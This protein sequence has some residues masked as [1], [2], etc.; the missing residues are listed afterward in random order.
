MS[1]LCVI[2]KI[3]Q[4]Y[5]SVSETSDSYST[6]A[7]RTTTINT[8]PDITGEATADWLRKAACLQVW[9]SSLY[10]AVSLWLLGLAIT[11]IYRLS[12]G[13]AHRALRPLPPWLLLCSLWE[14][15]T[16]WGHRMRPALTL[17]SDNTPTSLVSDHRSSFTESRMKLFPVCE[18]VPTLYTH[19]MGVRVEVRG[20]L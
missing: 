15:Q 16:R 3:G 7:S 1:K 9:G 13:D 17:I 11:G 2:D 20:Q 6:E 8:H 14:S 12:C 19:V 10:P 4:D 18:H 5:Q